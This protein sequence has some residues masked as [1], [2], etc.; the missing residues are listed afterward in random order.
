MH[1]SRL[2]LVNFKT[3]SELDVGLSPR[4]NCFVGNNGVGKTNL[5]DAVYYLAF[6]KSCFNGS[7]SDSIRHQEDFF[8]VRGDFEFSDRQEKIHCGLKRDQKKRVTRND[9]E[10]PR[11][12]DHIGLI[13]MVMV[14]PADS[15]LILEG[16]EERRRYINGVIS[17]YDRQYLDDVM[18]YNKALLQRNRLLKEFARSGFFDGESLEVWD[19][20]MALLGERIFTR[21]REFISELLPVFRHYYEFISQG[22]ELVDLSYRSQAFR[23]D[24]AKQMRKAWERDRILQFSTVGIHKDDLVL[25]LAGFPIRQQGSQGQQK[26]YLVALKMA[27]Y[28]FLANV[29]P[30]QPLMLFD[31]LFD[32]LDSSRVTQIIKLVSDEKFGQIFLTD[33]NQQHLETIL[34][35]MPVDHKLFRVADGQLTEL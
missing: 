22:S 4:L 16:S 21:R 17:Q 24:L 30:S 14:S 19:H 7:D 26:T 18:R 6:G 35:Q 10:Y 23:G 31:D 15:S 32:K 28:E 2:S 34:K 33:T 1:L 29:S 13:P 27:Q 11:L 8:M 5:F 12:A 3:Y 9:K 25:E 20:Q